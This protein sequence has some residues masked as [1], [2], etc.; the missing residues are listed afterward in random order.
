MAAARSR[1]ALRWRRSGQALLVA[2][3]AS[4]ACGGAALAPLE[5]T[6]YAD[7]AFPDSLQI[8]L[9]ADRPH[10]IV[11]ATNFGLILSEDD[12][13]TWSWVCEPDPNDNAIFYQLGAS[14]GDRLYATLLG[15]GLVYSDDGACTWTPAGGAL[16]TARATD[17]FP[18][19]SDP[20]RVLAIGSE[21]G[22]A[23]TPQSLFVSSDGGVTFGPA[24][25]SAP[26]DGGLLGV[27]SARS[28]P[29]TIYLSMYTTPGVHPVLVRS[30]DGGASFSTMDLGPVLGDNG[31]RI[32]AVDPEDP[33]RLY[34]RVT[35]DLGEKLA[36][37]RD[38]GATFSEP[39]GTDD[40][41]T[42]FARLASGTV[43]VAGSSTA[44]PVGFRSTDGGVTF[45]PWS[46]VP[47]LRALAERD[48][49]LYAA[50]DN[51][52]DGFAVGVSTDEGLTFRPI[53]TYD[54]VVGIKPCA[55]S[56]C[57]A[58]CDNLAGLTLWPP[59]VCQAEGTPMVVTPPGHGC[60][61]GVTGRAAPSLPGVA[62]ALLV[63]VGLAVS[64]R[65]SKLPIDP[66]DQ[67][68][69]PGTCAA[70]RRSRNGSAIR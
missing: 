48:G 37:T 36:V 63:G 59:S 46:N 18:D 22:D 66:S 40:V 31:F 7:G 13:A 17:V 19:P 12:G 11:L 55:K 45:Q 1:F 53:L 6:A 16:A 21:R 62:L 49:K 2:L 64:R 51:F 8:L 65:R 58:S 32:I 68:S 57:Q 69:T 26:V 60:D 20:G 5:G 54:K 39:V 50:A 27:E 38:G 34:L 25:Y 4:L 9:P 41:L 3:V 67:C 52:R 35:E 43:L 56:R 47:H 28:R 24:L 14:P 61:C 42:A 29:A 10:Q 70:R 33:Q 44:G 23:R 15:A 30:D